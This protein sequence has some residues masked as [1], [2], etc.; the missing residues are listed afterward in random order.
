MK[1]N[2]THIIGCYRD[3]VERVPCIRYQPEWYVRRDG[4]QIYRKFGVIRGK[5]VDSKGQMVSSTKRQRFRS[6]PSVCNFIQF[7]K[8]CNNRLSFQKNHYLC[9]ELRT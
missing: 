5:S 2:G 7:F 9:I 4:L 1:H 3:T 6:H 8:E